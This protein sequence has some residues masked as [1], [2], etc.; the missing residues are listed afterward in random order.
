[1]ARRNEYTLKTLVANYITTDGF[2][3]CDINDGYTRFYDESKGELDVNLDEFH[4][5][6]GEPVVIKLRYIYG[7]SFTL[8]L[9]GKVH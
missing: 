9:D 8:M 1:P 6:I 2:V 7:V 4:K 5:Q 3:A